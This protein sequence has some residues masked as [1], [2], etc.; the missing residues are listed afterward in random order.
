MMI[1]PTIEQADQCAIVQQEFVETINRLMAEGFDRRIISSGVGAAVAAM[2]GTFYGPAE[3]PKWFAKQSV[4]TM[5]F[6]S[7]SKPN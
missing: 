1:D 3:V 2:V 5:H 7:V 6:A 4:M